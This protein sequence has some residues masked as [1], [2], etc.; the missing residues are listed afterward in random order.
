MKKLLTAAIIGAAGI[1]SAAHAARNCCANALCCLATGSKCTYDSSCSSTLTCECDTLDNGF[2]NKYGIIVTTTKKPEAYCVGQTAYSRCVAG[3]TT[4]KCASGYYGTATSASAGCTAC[5]ANA[6]CAGGN[7]STF[8][9]KANYYKSGAACQPCP[10]SGK[11]T[12]GS[13]SITSCYLP[14]GTTF[15]DSTGSGTYSDKCYYSN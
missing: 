12:A 7:G 15:S 5:P 9:C 8:I 14:S 3:T 2:T 1:S 10:N 11:S 13:T 6:T 4:Y